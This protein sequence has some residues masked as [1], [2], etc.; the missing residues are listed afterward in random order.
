MGSRSSQKLSRRRRREDAVAPPLSL[1]EVQDILGTL[2]AKGLV[3]KDPEDERWRLTSEAATHELRRELKARGF[4]L[5]DGMNLFE[6]PVGFFL[7][8]EASLLEVVA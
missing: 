5:A 1:E 2:E 3:E 8:R 6:F 7:H 4:E